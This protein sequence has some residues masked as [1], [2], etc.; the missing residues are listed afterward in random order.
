MPIQTLGR[1]MVITI[2]IMVITI[3]ETNIFL[4]LLELLHSTKL[5]CPAP[6]QTLGRIMAITAAETKIEKLWLVTSQTS[7]LVF[8]THTPAVI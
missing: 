7:F 6:I 8:R 4:R 2:R 5:M 1:F 3:T